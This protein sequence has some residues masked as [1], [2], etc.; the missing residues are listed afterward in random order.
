MLVS[1]INRYSQADLKNALKFEVIFQPENFG[2]RLP[3]FHF[4][5]Q[6]IIKKTSLSN[7]NRYSQADLKN[8]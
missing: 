4:F 6:L 1:S 5:K 7:I 3:K 8:A 2:G